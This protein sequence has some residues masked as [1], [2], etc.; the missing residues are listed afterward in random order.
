M[1]YRSTCRRRL[2]RY[3]RDHADERK[4][5]ATGYL[6]VLSLSSVRLVKSAS[7]SGVQQLH[8]RTHRTT[9]AL[10]HHGTSTTVSPDVH[11]STPA[12]LPTSIRAHIQGIPFPPRRSAR[13]PTL[14]EPTLLLP[15]FFSTPA[16]LHLASPTAPGRRASLDSKYQRLPPPSPSPTARITYLPLTLASTQPPPLLPLP[17]PLTPASTTAKQKFSLCPSTDLSST[18]VA[19]GTGES[20]RLATLFLGLSALYLL[21]CVALL[22]SILCHC[23]SPASNCITRRALHALHLHLSINPSQRLRLPVRVWCWGRN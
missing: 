8:A 1:N 16:P 22:C 21:C 6:D 14:T 9:T 12:T 4:S 18:G 7:Q 15:Q 23:T 13:H 11:D 19:C 10:R 5:L 2:R 3:G 17:L 20:G